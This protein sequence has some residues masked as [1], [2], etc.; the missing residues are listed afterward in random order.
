MPP[1][2]DELVIYPIK[3]IKGISLTESKVS[4]SGLENDRR[5]M[6]VTPNGDFITGRTHPVLTLVSAIL[7]PHSQLQLSHPN[8]DTSITIDPRSLSQTRQDVLVWDD[9]VNGRR[10][11]PEADAWFSTILGKSVQLIQFDSQSS[12]YTHRRPDSPVAFADGYP[13]LITSRASLEQ[14]D[15]Y[16][17]EPVV[18]AQFRSNLIIDDCEPFAEDT[19]QRIQIGDVIFESAKPCERCIFTTL[20]PETAKS[21]KKGEPL[22]TLAK[23]RLLGKEGVTFGMNFVAINEGRI[24]QGDS[25]KILETRDPEIYTNRFE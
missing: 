9:T 13:F 15:R 8:Q 24:R 2:L 10:C 22:R 4:L 23:F 21:G 11:S 25:V 6:L 18:M 20:N 17:P 3:S 19:W 1:Q 5:Y 7:L 12:R 16:C 14:L